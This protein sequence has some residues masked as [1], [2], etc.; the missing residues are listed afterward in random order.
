M[1]KPERTIDKINGKKVKRTITPS[2]ANSVPP[3]LN[4]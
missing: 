1:P 4:I 2:D 3:L